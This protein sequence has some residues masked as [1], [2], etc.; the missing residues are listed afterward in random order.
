MDLSQLIETDWH[1][2]ETLEKLAHIEATAVDAINLLFD[3]SNKETSLKQKASY[4]FIGMFQTVLADTCLSLDNRL[5]LLQQLEDNHG[6]SDIIISAYSR[7]MKAYQFRGSLRTDEEA[8]KENQFYPSSDQANNYWD[9]VID[10]LKGITV[11]KDNPMNEAAL[12]AIIFRLQEQLIEGSSNSMLDAIEEIAEQNGLSDSL[13]EKLVPLISD[14]YQL[15]DDVFKRVNNLLEKYYPE[16]PEGE[17]IALVVKAPWVNVMTATGQYQDISKSKA[18][19]LAA[20]F[21]DEKVDWIQHLGILLQGD[22]RQTFAFAEVLGKKVTN[23]DE[24]LKAVYESYLEIDPKIHNSAFVM[25][26]IIGVG[27]DEFTRS[28]IDLLISNNA[29]T[30]HGIRAINH[31]NSIKAEDIDKC[32][33]I[34]TNKPSLLNNIEYVNLSPLTSKEVI[35]VT[36]WIKDIN[37]SFALQLIWELLRRNNN[38]WAELKDHLNELLWV[39]KLLGFRTSINSSFHIEDLIISSLK[40]DPEPERIHFLT[41][42]ILIEY[43][44]YSMRN[45]GIVDRLLH[46][47]FQNYWDNSWPFLGEY[48]S[49][50]KVQSNFGLNNFLNHYK[51]ENSKLY[52]W[53]KL[54]SSYP[55]IALKYMRIDFVNDEQQRVWD[56]IALKLVREN[57]DIKEVREVLSSKFINYSIHGI[58]AEKL[59]EE[60]KL[61]LEKLND[62]ESNEFKNFLSSLI[63]RIDK[64]IERERVDR[65]NYDL[66]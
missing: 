53:S 5:E 13:R 1:T 4:S 54:D 50:R 19:E 41:K 30:I 65:E 25:G 37:H 49:T 28:A 51:F 32:K 48:L 16:T 27:D 14:R 20:R 35:R 64:N 18:Q 55:V 43:Q 40:D 38:R 61:L 11:D 58:S 8:I 46:H 21:I 56:P 60:R 36:A 66:N 26:F 47:L 62:I 24:I 2:V 44:D 39:N 34:F 33:E 52:N 12:E 10:K 6:M 59:Y 45:E 9:S 29:T 22:Q 15:K 3:L 7:A 23:R 42:E 31:L 63:D 17:L 57:A